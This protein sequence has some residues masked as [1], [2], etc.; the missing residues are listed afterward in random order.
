VIH[1]GPDQ[2]DAAKKLL[3]EE[4]TNIYDIGVGRYDVAIAV[5][6][7]Y[8]S[9]RQQAV[10]TQL[11]LLKMLPPELVTSFADLVI[12]NMDI[13]QAKELADRAHKLLPPQLQDDDSDPQAMVAKLQG[14]LQQMGQ[15]GQIMAQK[16]QEATQIIQTKKVEH[17]AKTQQVLIQEQNA[18]NIAKMKAEVELAIAEIETKA[19]VA[20]ERAQALQELHSDL[21]EAAH[22][23]ALQTSQQGHEQQQAASQQQADAQ[24][25]QSDQQHQQ[26]S[27][28]SDPAQQQA[29]AQQAQESQNAGD[30]NSGS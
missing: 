9:K 16:L 22:E 13:P 15:Q 17:D 10:A 7:S 12:R 19:Q 29:M 2:A 28:A 21:H 14:Q 6:P 1:N 30:G 24:S 5:G 3:T 18:F 25:Q 27:Q 4:I 26:Q 8:Q 11:E 23:T 20:S